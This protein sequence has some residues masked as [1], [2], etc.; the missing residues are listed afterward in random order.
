MNLFAP[1]LDSVVNC[2]SVCMNKINSIPTLTNYIPDNSVYIGNDLMI[3]LGITY[4]KK[5]VT[6]HL[7]DENHAMLV[8]GVS[9]S[10]KSNFINL[11]INQLLSY[12]DVELYLIDSKIVELGRYSNIRQCKAFASDEQSITNLLDNILANI[13][14]DYN[15]LLANNRV[16][17]KPYE[18]AKVVIVEELALLTKQ[19]L[20]VLSQCVAIGRGVGYRFII[21]IQRADGNVMNNQLKS[22]LTTRIAFRCTNKANSQLIIET[23]EATT[24]KNRGRCYVLENGILKEV[25]SYLINEQIIIETINRNLKPKIKNVKEKVQIKTSVQN[26]KANNNTETSSTTCD[27]SWIDKI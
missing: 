6:I 14:E 23:D 24:I 17:V 13:K 5:E 3:R 15:N 10:G 8:A 7:N 20:K 27:T 2:I 18:K 4:G 19:Q 22:L 26:S 12:K 16:K 21:S 1:L 11:S 9:G 25:Q